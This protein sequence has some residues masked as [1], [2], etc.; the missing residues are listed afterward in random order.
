M[1]Q[2][3]EAMDRTAAIE[4][5]CEADLLKL[6]DTERAEQIEVMMLEDW[7]EHPDWLNL[8]ASTRAEMESGKSTVTL[9]DTRYHPILLMWLRNRYSAAKNEFLLSQLQDLGIHC[10]SVTGSPTMLE[11]CPCCGLRTIAS[12]GDYEICAVCWWEDDGQDNAQAHLVYGGPNGSL[13]LSRARI[14]V[15]LFGISDP[16]REDLRQIQDPQEKY[17]QGRSFLLTEDGKGVREPSEN[18]VD[19]PT[20]S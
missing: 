15:L 18:W 20:V 13:S 9:L 5:I 8:P 19:R 10:Q 17:L 3:N 2:K 16:S 1:T 12:R 7:S 4:I 11:A 14:N 6:N